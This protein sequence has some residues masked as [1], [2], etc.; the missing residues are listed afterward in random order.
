MS[1][2]DAFERILASLYDAM[3]DDALWPATSALIDEACGIRGNALL[4]G[5]NLNNAVQI[6]FG[7]AYYRGERREDWEREY[8]EV[9]HPIDERVPRVRQLP[10][11]HLVHITAL[12]T[13]EE[14]QT[15]PTYNEM[16]A[17][18]SGQDGLNVR[19]DGP[20]GSHITWS[21][22]DPVG[23]GSW[24]SSQL[25]LIKGLLPHL[26]QFVRVRQALVSAE[27]LSASVTEL[28]DTS[29]MGVIHLDQRGQ[30][31]A[32][33]DRARALL[34]RGDGLTD[35]GGVLRAGVPADHAR[36]GQ[37]VAG[38]LPPS[39]VAAVSGS[40]PLRRATVSL[41]FVVHVTPVGS[42]QPD[43]GAQRVAA[44]V[45]VV[46]PGRQPRIEPGLVAATLGLT[47]AE[48]YIAVWLA[49]GQSVREMAEATGR[50]DA[51]IH[52]HL[53]QMYQ[54]LGISRQVDLTRLV[55]SLVEGV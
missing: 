37:L 55:L 44:L 24:A 48:S 8:L 30:I 38:A 22:N 15:S 5:A 35:R 12:Y 43:F 49:Q 4:V 18:A 10:D 52:Y 32:A 53:H 3:L 50:T 42:R 47:P 23:P 19:L 34:R 45:L 28:L 2:Q 54:K 25:A 31:M 16:M 29:R 11:S 33:N 41:P 21:L 9:Y 26:R 13:A 7:Q 36:L 20:N 17:R 27:A 46:E 51:T 39:G 40:M 6:L 14:L 1:D